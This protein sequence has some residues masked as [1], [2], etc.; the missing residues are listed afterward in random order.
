MKLATPR[1]TAL[2]SSSVAAAAAIRQRR[3][4]HQRHGRRDVAPFETRTVG[5]VTP[6]R[7]DAD[8]V[9]KVFNLRGGGLKQWD[10]GGAEL[11]EQRLL[12]GAPAWGWGDA[13]TAV[14]VLGAFA[15]ADVLCERVALAAARVVAAR[16]EALLV[17][18]GPPA[19]AAGSLAAAQ[20]RKAELAEAVPDLVSAVRS[21]SRLDCPR[22]AP[23][24]RRIF[25]A[26][27]AAT[28]AVPKAPPL[29]PR[30]LTSVV[31]AAGR[32][33]QPRAFA[34]FAAAA[35]AAAG[36]D[37]LAR[38]EGLRCLAHDRGGTLLEASAGVVDAALRR[39][40]KRGEGSE[41][42]A[43]QAL[44]HLG[45]FPLSWQQKEG[46]RAVVARVAAAAE[47]AH[48][49]REGY[50]D[51]LS[52]LGRTKMFGL[53]W[54]AA[55]GEG[56]D[57]VVSGLVLRACRRTSAAVPPLSPNHLGSLLA[58]LLR[59]KKKAAFSSGGGG[60]GG[61]RRLQEKMKAKNK[62]A[63]RGSLSEPATRALA[64]AAAEA[65]EAA[66]N[67]EGAA[68]SCVQQLARSV[69]GCARMRLAPPPER[70][71]GRL[72]AVRDGA[73]YA[74]AED[75][76][77]HVGL[78]VAQVL[79]AAAR[80]AEAAPAVLW[81]RHLR[82]C[83]DEHTRR[84]F[85]AEDVRMILCAA[86]AAVTTAKGD[87]NG[88]AAAAAAAA[89]GPA[90]ASALFGHL[91]RMRLWGD[92]ELVP[93]GRVLAA[94]AALRCRLTPTQQANA[95]AR[96]AQVLEGCG[97]DGVR[98]TVR[99]LNMLGG[100]LASACPDAG[101]AGAAGGAR[102]A[103]VRCVERILEESWAAVRGKKPDDDE[104]AR[105]LALFGGSSLPLPN[106][107]REAPLV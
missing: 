31:G 65:L 21:L 82:M 104:K 15:R 91:T 4:V 98:V 73:A 44:R 39:Y 83:L 71:W 58:S 97:G 8:G 89:V 67:A 32:L 30:Q 52:A 70:V 9:T 14:I 42:E 63:P 5:I 86:A 61:S 75:G 29:S 92:L 47:T 80:D 74:A 34:F 95:V 43:V 36:A 68:A 103:L 107:P 10:L 24:A 100:A 23:L 99:D 54:Y 96:A 35:F 3:P 46:A 20:P 16:A 19:T 90:A 94:A 56:E 41:A 11:T 17:L 77:R 66:G 85:K 59:L 69:W 76:E 26:L 18:P 33:R 51:V 49:G 1:T 27:A 62:K 12:R 105:I 55:D 101:S 13:K 50:V 102:A 78:A 88:A 40:G 93:L 6:P 28:T 64:A 81:T 57:D 22:A 45:A 53:A 72:A 106:P 60:G 79:D 87:G 84:G 7:V 25:S 37:E 38:L 48:V 2:V